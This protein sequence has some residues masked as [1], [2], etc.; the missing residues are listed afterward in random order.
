MAK[1]FSLL[2][3]TVCASLLLVAAIV[4]TLMTGD[5]WMH[6][7]QESV[8]LGIDSPWRTAA[9]FIV[10]VFPWPWFAVV[11]ISSLGAEG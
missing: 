3:S 6:D 9:S 11:R 4:M 1:I 8:Q 5:R 2:Y 10:F 7:V